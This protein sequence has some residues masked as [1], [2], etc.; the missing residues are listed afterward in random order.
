MF[1]RFKHL[2]RYFSGN[3]KIAGVDFSQYG[4]IGAVRSLEVTYNLQL[5]K[6]KEYHPHLHCIFALKKNLNLE[7]DIVNKFSYSGKSFRSAFS[8]F[9]VLL[10]KIWYLLLTKQ[11]VNLSAINSIPDGYSVKIDKCI[12]T[13]TGVS[14]YYEVFKYAMKCFNTKVDNSQSVFLQYNQFKTLYL[15]LYKCRT[16]QGYGKLHNIKSDENV[17]LKSAHALYY[18]FLKSLNETPVKTSNGLFEVLDKEPDENGKLYRYITGKNVINMLNSGE[19]KCSPQMLSCYA[20]F[21]EDAENEKL[22]MKKM[23]TPKFRIKPIVNKNMP[24]SLTDILNN[25]QAINFKEVFAPN[26]HPVK[27]QTIEDDVF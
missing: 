26:V 23:F 8:N 17:D 7:K 3:L 14:G 16:I 15:A 5:P 12:E 22:T 24:D 21:K 13:D 11:R 1:D 20:Q 6:T 19:L 4:F 18:D 10:Q 25:S 2:I 27:Q 9:E